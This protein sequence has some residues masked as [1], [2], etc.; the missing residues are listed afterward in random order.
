MLTAMSRIDTIFNELRGRGG[1]AI[2]PFVT[3]GDPDVETTVEVVKALDRAGASVCELG[4]P[5]SDPIA[6]G[7]VIQ[8]SMTRALDGGVKVGRVFDAVRSVRGEVSIGLVAMCSYSIVFRKG[9]EAF[10]H[11]AAEAGVDGLILPDLSLEEAGPAREA[12]EAAGLALSLLI[13]PTTPIER[14]QRI[15]AASSGF[16]YIVSR[17]GITGESADLPPE[18]PERL[19]AIREATDLPLAVGFGIATPEQVRA[20]VQQADAAIVGSALVRRIHDAREAG[21]DPAA[22][23]ERFVAELAGGLEEEGLRAEGY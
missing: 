11:E 7:P 23:A 13:A 9:L 3:A 16:V 18:L 22:A 2:M 4:I 10:C 5:F 14:A 19:A 8:A 21:D 15:A 17:K 20:V 1:R 12:A 6:D